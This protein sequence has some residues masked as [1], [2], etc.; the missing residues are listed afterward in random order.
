[1]QQ[2]AG[3]AVANVVHPERVSLVVMRPMS[4]T[5]VVGR[6]RDDVIAELFQVEYAGLVRLAYVIVRDRCSAED[7]VMEAFCSLHAHWGRVRSKSAP[8]A[9][10]RTAVIFGSRSRVRELVRERGR[11]QISEVGVTDPNSAQAIARDEA[12][13]LAEAVR[14]LPRRQREVVVCRYYLD[15]SEAETAGTLGISVG[16]VKRHAHRA[17]ETLFRN[18]EV[19]R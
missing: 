7:V 17:R 8:L 19:D 12:G 14:V 5:D 10:L 16:A 15:L 3:E 11:R 6:S 13:A 1:M 18:V 2:P 9:Y 4:P